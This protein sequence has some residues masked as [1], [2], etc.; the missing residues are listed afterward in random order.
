LSYSF[1]RL[2]RRFSHTF[3]AFPSFRS[4]AHC[5]DSIQKQD[6]QHYCKADLIRW[7]ATGKADVEFD[8][9]SKQYRIIKPFTSPP[10]GTRGYE[11]LQ[12]LWWA[13]GLGLF[14]L[15]ILSATILLR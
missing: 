15:V 4:L 3:L 5:L 6:G 12:Q 8:A 10:A 14:L 7:L 2:N 13:I 1:Y 11:G 9:Q